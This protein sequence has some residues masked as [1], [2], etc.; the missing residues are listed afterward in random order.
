MPCVQAGRLT[1]VFLTDDQEEE[2]ESGLFLLL[3]CFMHAYI[4]EWSILAGSQKN[5]G[6]Q[7]FSRAPQGWV[8]GQVVGSLEFLVAII[9]LAPTLF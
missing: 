7:V 8:A 9:L 3:V 4:T 2:N 6:Y 5:P 1:Q